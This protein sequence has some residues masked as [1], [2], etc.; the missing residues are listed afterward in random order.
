MVHQRASR[1]PF[2][3]GTKTHAHAH[4]HTRTHRA[5]LY[6]HGTLSI[7]TVP[8]TNAFHLRLEPAMTEAPSEL[9]QIP[10][11]TRLR[12]PSPPSEAPRRPMDDWRSQD[13]KT[14]AS[15]SGTTKKQGKK[16]QT[17]TGSG[18]RRLRS[19]T[20]T[21][22]GGDA[23]DGPQNSKKTQPHAMKRSQSSKTTTG[24]SVDTPLR[25]FHNKSTYL[26]ALPKPDRHTN[27]RPH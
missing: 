16:L 2:V 23:E 6:L 13:C 20:H 12:K 4:A 22:S 8:T 10:S 1:K 18:I 27:G 11:S 17:T 9:P 7:H 5:R 19:F 15:I 21:P 25:G 14:R 26:H 3:T 24:S